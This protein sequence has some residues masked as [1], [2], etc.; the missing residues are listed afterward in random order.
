MWKEA[1]TSEDYLRIKPRKG[2]AL[3]FYNYGPDGVLDMASPHMSC[4]V[5]KGDKW[6]GQFWLLNGPLDEATGLPV[7]DVQG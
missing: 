2:A 1:C 4:P 6:I 3:L 7:Q 5:I